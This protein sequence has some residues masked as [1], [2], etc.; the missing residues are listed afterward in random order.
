MAL[1]CR[2]PPPSNTARR[3]AA[4]QRDLSQREHRTRIQV[5]LRTEGISHLGDVGD[6]QLAVVSLAEVM[7]AA[8]AQQQ[9]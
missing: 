6:L 9:I 5:S 1:A 8:P 7:G 3:N 2:T 4:Q